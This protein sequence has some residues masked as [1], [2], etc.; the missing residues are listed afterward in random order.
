MHA[1]S[2]KRRYHRS[3]SPRETGLI[4]TGWQP[5][6]LK[7]WLIGGWP[8]AVDAQLTKIDRS[9]SAVDMVTQFVKTHTTPSVVGSRGHELVP[10]HPQSSVTMFHRVVQSLHPVS[11]RSPRIAPR[12]MSG[13][14]RGPPPRV[15]GSGIRLTVMRGVACSTRPAPQWAGPGGPERRINQNRSGPLE[16]PNATPDGT[17]PSV[18]GQALTAVGG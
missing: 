14:L 10:R 18:A 16:Q 5:T 9:S 3:P 6:A 15:P 8:T 13:S 1:K 2:R 17:S 4:S 11:R 12:A 7:R